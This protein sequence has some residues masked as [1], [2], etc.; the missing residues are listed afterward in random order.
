MRIEQSH[1]VRWNDAKDGWRKADSHLDLLS[2]S[3]TRFNS[4]VALLHRRRTG[5]TCGIANVHSTIPN[6]G[7]AERLKLCGN[8]AQWNVSASIGAE[9]E[10]PTSRDE[11]RGRQLMKV[12]L[13][14]R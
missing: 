13:G 5:G 12:L 1:E 11:T 14:E 2:T 6:G 7:K 4:S 9:A 10:R 8:H 3:P